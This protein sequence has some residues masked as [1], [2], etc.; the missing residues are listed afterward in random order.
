MD[1]DNIFEVMMTSGLWF[2]FDADHKRKSSSWHLAGAKLGTGPALVIVSVAS[3]LRWQSSCVS[4]VMSYGEFCMAVAWKQDH[5]ML[6]PCYSDVF[7]FPGIVSS[8]VQAEIKNIYNALCELLRH[9]WTCFPATSKFLEEKVC[10][11]TTSRQRPALSNRFWDSG[12]IV[13]SLRRRACLLV[14]LTQNQHSYSCFSHPCCLFFFSLSFCLG[15]S[16][17]LSLSLFLFH[18]NFFS[19]WTPQLYFSWYLMPVTLP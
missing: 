6:T 16:V 19:E 10:N 8:D 7:C 14:C 9:F 5:V 2:K 13:W 11:V 3:V 4:Q 12:L 1:M 17:C 18:F 15:L